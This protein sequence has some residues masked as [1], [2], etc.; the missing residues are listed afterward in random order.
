MSFKASLPSAA[1]AAKEAPGAQVPVT[2]QSCPTRW[3]LNAETHKC[4]YLPLGNI[5]GSH[6]DVPW[7]LPQTHTEGGFI[8]LLGVYHP[9]SS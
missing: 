8:N 4:N 7:R 1:Y 9:K 6:H 3:R 2:C 5:P